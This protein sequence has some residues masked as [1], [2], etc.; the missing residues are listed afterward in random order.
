MRTKINKFFATIEQAL[1]IRRK[2]RV[3]ANLEQA[4]NEI[5]RTPLD[6]YS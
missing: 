5:N 1:N 4:L 6:D 3:E 2:R